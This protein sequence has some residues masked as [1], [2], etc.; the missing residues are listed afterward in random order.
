MSQIEELHSRITAAMDRIGVGVEALAAVPVAQPEPQV[1]EETGPDPD[2][3]AAL[4]DE[5][6]ANAQLE[7]R[8]R[9]LKARH[10]AELEEL[11]QQGE[12]ATEG[13]D[14]DIDA[15]RAEIET[16]R[17]AAEDRSEVEALNAELSEA[18]A[19]LAAV[20]AAAADAPDTDAMQAELEGLRSQLEQVEDPEPLRAEINVLRS[21]MAENEQAADLKSELE[22]LRAERVSQGAAMARLD[23][24]LQQLRKSNDKLREVNQALREANAAGVGDADLINGALQAE[25]EALRAARAT[26]AAEAGAILARL[27]PLLAQADLAEGEDE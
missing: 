10:E 13:S 17:A 27:E 21:A 23:E 5:K 24:D 9:T 3:A 15:L 18:R 20:D 16:L 19:R 4:E 25:A 11:R 8:L 22:M 12:P 26:D 2:L 6:L 14:E 7:E 1:S